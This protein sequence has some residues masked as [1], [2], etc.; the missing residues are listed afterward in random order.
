MD[1]KKGV[2]LILATAI[3]SGFAIFINKFSVS[4]IEPSVFVFLKNI[5]VAVFLFSVILITKEFNNLRML[6]R[7]QWLKLGL[8][9]LIGGSI[10]FLL[11]FKGLSLTSAASGAFMHKTLFIYASIFAFFLLKEKTNKKIFLA[12]VLLLIGNLLLLKLKVF[13]FGIGEIFILGAT[14]FWA[15]ENVL[16][17]HTLKELS[18]NLVAFGR[19]FFGSLFILVFL[20]FSNKLSGVASISLIN[21]MWVLITSMFLLLFVVTYY[22]GLK[23]V[24]V[25]VATS[26]LLLGSPITT[27]LSFMFTDAAVAITQFIG[28]IFIIAGVGISVFFVEF[29]SK[30]EVTVSQ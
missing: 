29:S 28:I 25:S 9:G 4:M 2:M 16:S 18:G 17:K 27:I 5:V 21:L 26:I 23:Y 12:A 11:F 1:Q 6:S 14:L 30:E 7:K 22:N 20:G 3:I 19:M 13:S 10:P 24:K 8:I 15:V